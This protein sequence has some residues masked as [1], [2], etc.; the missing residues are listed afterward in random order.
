MIETETKERLSET[1]RS[2]EPNESN[3]YFRTFYPKA[4]EYT[5]FSG[6]HGTF[7]KLNI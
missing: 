5:F 1:N 4:K 6:P 3:R 2:Y 7:S